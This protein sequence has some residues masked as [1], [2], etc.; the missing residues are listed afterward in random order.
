ME[1]LFILLVNLSIK[2]KETIEVQTFSRNDELRNYLRNNEQVD[3][4]LQKEATSLTEE[5]KNY[6]EILAKFIYSGTE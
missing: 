6:R 4:L 2:S 1:L 3:A 5:E